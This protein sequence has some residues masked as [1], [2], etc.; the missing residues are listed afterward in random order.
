VKLIQYF[1][2]TTEIEDSNS[3]STINVVRLLFFLFFAAF[4]IFVPYINVYYRAIGLSGIQIGLVNTLSPLVG[5]FSGPLW[6]MISDRFGLNRRILMATLAGVILAVIG[7]SVVKVFIWILLLAAVYSL[8]NN[9]FMPLLDSIGLHFL[10]EYRQQYG[11]LRIWGSIGFII[12]TSIIGYILE[13][14]GL[15][16]LFYGYTVLMLL[17]LVVLIWLPAV[18]PRINS[19]VWRGLS[20]LIRNPTWLVFSAS[21]VLLGLANNGMYIF[22][23]IYI[24]EL[25]GNN[26]L[27]GTAMSLGA[28]TE[29]PFMLFSAPLIMR[30]GSHRTLALAYFF[31]AAR[32]FLYGIM[33]S[34]WWVLP[35]SLMH[36]ITFGIYW[37]SAVSYANDLA[38]GNLKATA[39]GMLLATI[40]LAAVLGG[41]IGG[42]VYDH[43]GL[44]FLF[45]LYSALAM[46]ALVLLG[47][48]R[49]V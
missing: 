37:V 3:R 6:G 7:I 22:L 39:Q 8:F 27:I 17:V 25:G 43:F 23:G 31:Y 38:P 1:I 47:V 26:V 14:C 10:G 28:I 29:L 34:A 15:H 19:S 16:T 11:R 12:S 42:L 18:K 41:I 46:I 24:T 13:Q 9:A 35:I 5:I 30:F 33:P 44:A 36:G 20:E 2:T 49:R 21:L 48:H 4:G 45:R 40:N 32:F